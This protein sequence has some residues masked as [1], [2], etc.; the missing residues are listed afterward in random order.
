MLLLFKPRIERSAFGRNR[1]KNNL[2]HVVLNNLISVHNKV[3]FSVKLFF[4]ALNLDS[5]KTL[6]YMYLLQ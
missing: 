2:I 1:S 4:G 3:W 6:V 5:V